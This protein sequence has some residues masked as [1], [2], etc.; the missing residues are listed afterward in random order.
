M[1]KFFRRIRR[2]LLD[3][4]S[5]RKYFFYAIGEIALVVIGILIALQ[6]NNWNESRKEE[7][8][9]IKLLH[10]LKSDLIGSINDMSQVLEIDSFVISNG[11][12]LIQILENDTSTY[13]ESMDELFGYIELW[14]PF[15]PRMMAYENLRSIGYSIISDDTLRSD[16]IYLFDNVYASQKTGAATL[17]SAYPKQLEVIFKHLKTGQNIF[18]KKPNDFEKIKKSEEYLNYLTYMVAGR[19][20]MMNN[21]KHTLEQMIKVMNQID[22]KLDYRSKTE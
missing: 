8:L 12:L 16:I 3:E 13:Q 4:A 1:L 2:K 18:Q 5:L 14:V 7:K 9:E 15:E 20:S 10:G 17:V 21:S 22:Q 11:K 19:K 6:I